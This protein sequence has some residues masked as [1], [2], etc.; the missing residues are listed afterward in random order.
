MGLGLLLFL[1]EF[2]TWKG[3]HYRSFF[4]LFFYHLF[5]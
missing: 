5:C 3:A 4:S 2:G 1:L